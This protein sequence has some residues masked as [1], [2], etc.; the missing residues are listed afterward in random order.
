[1]RA[2]P[3]GEESRCRKQTA[4][5]FLVFLCLGTKQG[6][7]RVGMESEGGKVTSPSGRQGALWRREQVIMTA[8]DNVCRKYSGFG[9][10]EWAKTYL[11]TPALGGEDYILQWPLL[12][13]AV[14]FPAFS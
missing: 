7:L 3:E 14:F 9:P 1:M 5:S 10:L 11:C 6:S 13:A 4:L 8:L 12:T 2:S